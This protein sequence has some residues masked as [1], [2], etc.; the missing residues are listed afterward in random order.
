[1]GSSV[2]RAYSVQKAAL[3]RALNHADPN[4]RRRAV[5]K[6]CRRVQSEW[7]DVWPDDWS[8]WQRALD[9]VRPWNESIRMEDL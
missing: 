7:G 4:E 2:S 1:M 9:D 6:E 8:R 5:E 3:T